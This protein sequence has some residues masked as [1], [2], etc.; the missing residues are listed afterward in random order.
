MSP[1][2]A[3]PAAVGRLGEAQKACALA[4][5]FR[6][7]HAGSDEALDWVTYGDVLAG[8]CLLDQWDKSAHERYAGR[9]ELVGSLLSLRASGAPVDV[10]V[11]LWIVRSWGAPVASGALQLAFKPSGVNHRAMLA[12]GAFACAADD[13]VASDPDAIVLSDK[14]AVRDFLARELVQL[15]D[16]VFAEI[17]RRT[18]YGLAGMWGMTADYIAAVALKR[19]RQQR[20]DRAETWN[21]AMELIDAM[22]ILQPRLRMRPR[23]YD[24][25]WPGGETAVAVKCACCLFFKTHQ[26]QDDRRFCS[27]CPLLS[28]ES[29]AQRVAGLLKREYEQHPLAPV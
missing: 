2:A 11:S 29:R 10:A 3:V 21:R 4:S 24:C 28:D 15:L 27:N 17:K 6:Q 14:L 22:R 25:T 23:R 9:R 8:R 1:A 7:F 16:P 12:G 5:D 18:P 20:R 13:P 26:D 19:A